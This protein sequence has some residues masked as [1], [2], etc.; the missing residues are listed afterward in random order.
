MSQEEIEEQ[1]FA[2]Q[3][4]GLSGAWHHP[5]PRE[6]GTPYLILGHGAG[7]S[8]ATPALV[9]FARGLAQRGIG[10]VRFNFPYREAGRKVP[11]RQPTLEA[12]YRE[13]AGQVAERI[14]GSQGRLFLGGRSM[15]GRIA[16]HIVADGVSARGLVFLGYPLHPPGKPDRLRDAHLS[17]ITVPM[18]FLSGSRDSFARK[19]L[20]E[21]TVE[22]LPNASLQ[23]I[24]GGDHGFAVP[25]RGMDEVMAEVAQTAAAWIRAIV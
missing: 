13:I 9:G 18:L 3:Q 14:A 4:G 23:A 2:W 17:R 10:A 5:K 12:C 6:A 7:G 20:L 22:R 24:P 1:S 21:A 8:F 19:D 15:G 16:S 25:G 11:D